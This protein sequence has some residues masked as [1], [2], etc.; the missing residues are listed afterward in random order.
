[1]KITMNEI[2]VREVAENFLM[3]RSKVAEVTAAS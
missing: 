3:I 2:P 1:M